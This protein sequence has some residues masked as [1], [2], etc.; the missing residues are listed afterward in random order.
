MKHEDFV[1][2]YRSGKLEA[3]IQQYDV[4]KLALAGVLPSGYQAA[5]NF[6][7]WIWILSWIAALPVGYFYGWYYGVG[8]AFLGYVLPKAIR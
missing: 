6:Y 8:L 3:H 4:N 2:R 5:T 7:A 1:E